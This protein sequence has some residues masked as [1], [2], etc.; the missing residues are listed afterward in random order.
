MSFSGIR[1]VKTDDEL[2]KRISD[3]VPGAVRL[4]PT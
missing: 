1:L 3:V 2:P 4:R